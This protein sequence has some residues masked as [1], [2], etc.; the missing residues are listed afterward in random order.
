MLE[1]R[2]VDGNGHTVTVPF[3]DTVLKVDDASAD[4]VAQLL[5]EGPAKTHVAHVHCLI[6][7]HA[8]GLSPVERELSLAR[9][10]S[11]RASDYRVTRHAV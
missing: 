10:R 9:I 2:L 11:I 1:L 6:R 4:A 7:E 3:I 8:E 5:L